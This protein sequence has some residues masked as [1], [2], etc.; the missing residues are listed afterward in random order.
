MVEPYIIVPGGL[1]VCLTTETTGQT[2]A[3]VIF[4]KD[5]RL[6]IDLNF[7]ITANK[8]RNATTAS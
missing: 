7:A 3:R 5:P 2:S 4:G 8:V 1:S 6:P